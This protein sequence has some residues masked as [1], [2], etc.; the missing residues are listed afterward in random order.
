MQQSDFN[1]SHWD[2]PYGTETTGNGFL[3]GRGG[4]GSVV[5]IP[6]MGTAF[7]EVWQQL[8]ALPVDPT[9]PT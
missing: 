6:M 9:A 7:L 8:R 3:T 4:F 5:A 2:A 1:E